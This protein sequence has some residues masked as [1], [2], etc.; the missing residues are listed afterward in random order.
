M[1]EIEKKRAVDIAQIAPETPV[2][3]DPYAAG[4]VPLGGQLD[5]LATISA[6]R[7]IK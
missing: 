5:A 3:L 1:G 4:A 6:G 7:K 2:M